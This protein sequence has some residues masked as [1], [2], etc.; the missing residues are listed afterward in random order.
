MTYPAKQLTEKLDRVQSLERGDIL[1][2]WNKA[3]DNPPF[4]GARRGTLQRGVS[5][6]EQAKA[7]ADQ[8]RPGCVG[9]IGRE[10]TE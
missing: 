4:K 6:A 9:V 10:F 8:D 3:Y 1:S 2:L 5:Y 7:Q